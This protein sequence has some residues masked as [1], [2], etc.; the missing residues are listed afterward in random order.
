MGREKATLSIESKQLI[1][2]AYEAA[3]GFAD[4][5]YVS[6]HDGNGIDHLK[7]ALPPE[8]TYIL[9]LYDNPRSVLLALLSSFRQ[10]QEEHIAV[11]PVD[12]PF[13]NPNVMMRMVSSCREY[14]SVIPLWPD[15]KL[16]A[17]HAIY[18][19]KTT[20]PVLEDLWKNTTLEVWQIAKKCKKTLFMSTEILAELDPSLLSLQDADTPVEF[21]SLKTAK[22]TNR[23]FQS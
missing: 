12:S 18:N 1:G 16:E 15:G 4:H 5:V 19:R 9:D 6:V 11:L 17:I 14:D 13:M 3:N 10:M 2:W 21:E 23:Q 8:T 7:P 22:F 20:L